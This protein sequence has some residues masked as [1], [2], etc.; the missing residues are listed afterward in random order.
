L[1]GEG[2]GSVLSSENNIADADLVGWWGKQYGSHALITSMGL[3]CRSHRPDAC[4]DV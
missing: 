2:T 3:I 1:T 4:T